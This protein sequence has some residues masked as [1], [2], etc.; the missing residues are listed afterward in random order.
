MGGEDCTHELAGQAGGRG[1]RD[2]VQESVQ[3]EDEENQTEEDPTKKGDRF[4][5]SQGLATSSFIPLPEYR[6]STCALPQVRYWSQDQGGGVSEL[7]LSAVRPLEVT[8]SVPSGGGA[9]VQ[10]G[11]CPQLWR[12][13]ATRLKARRPAGDWLTNP[14]L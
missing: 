6:A 14:L 13:E 10:S 2:E 12:S 5:F 1:H 3:T 7:P 4:H 8:D 9:P 11:L